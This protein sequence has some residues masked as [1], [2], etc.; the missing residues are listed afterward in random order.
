MNSALATTPIGDRII[1]P[2]AHPVTYGHANQEFYQYCPV[3]GEFKNRK[4]FR[5]PEGFDLLN[6]SSLLISTCYPR[7]KAT[8]FFVLNGFTKS[9][10]QIV[11]GKFQ[12]PLSENWS[13]KYQ[14]NLMC[15]HGSKI[16]SF[17]DDLIYKGQT[18]TDISFNMRAKPGDDGATFPE[19]S[20]YQGD[21]AIRYALQYDAL[22]D[23]SRSVL[24]ERIN[25]IAEHL[26]SK[27]PFLLNVTDEPR[28]EFVEVSPLDPINEVKEDNR[29]IECSQSTD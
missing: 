12:M 25:R 3:T 17:L 8:P 29:S 28:E 7:G 26:G 22:I 16:V 13:D 23:R 10:G 14:S 20:V 19:F 6:L 1:V 5:Y 24:E 21:K 18:L 11:P 15:Y 4:V 27:K 9:Q 2:D